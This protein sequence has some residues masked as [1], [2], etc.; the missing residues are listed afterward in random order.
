MTSAIVKEQTQSA[1][2]DFKPQLAIA[3][4]GASRPDNINVWPEKRGFADFG[5]VILRV[6]VCES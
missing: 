1:R 3:R 5:G 4:S 2:R 6:C